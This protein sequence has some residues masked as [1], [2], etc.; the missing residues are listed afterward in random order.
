MD[1]YCSGCATHK[2]FSGFS[3]N[4][5][6]KDGYANWCKA[7][8][9]S[10]WQK[11]ENLLRRKERRLVNYANTLYVET[12]SRARLS[13]IEFNL[14]KEDITIPDVCPVLG[15]P[16]I[17]SLHGRTNNTPTVDKIIPSKGYVKGNVKVVS[18]LVNNIK[19]DC[20]DPE[21]FEKIAIYLRRAKDE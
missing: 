12:K 2:P 14:D 19:S 21:V 18:W 15:I 5:V 17:V 11:P 6:M 10:L 20:I 4:R 1:K 8:L 9:K 13:N 16:L 3:K 7:C